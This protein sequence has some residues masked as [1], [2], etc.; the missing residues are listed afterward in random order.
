M[1]HL[2]LRIASALV[3][4]GA[5]TGTATTQ[6]KTHE[7]AKAP[8]I[9]PTGFGEAVDRDVANS[10]CGDGPVHVHRLRDRGRLQASH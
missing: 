2:T 3:L 5:L 8:G 6:M 9:V 4:T 10:T 7:M 1:N